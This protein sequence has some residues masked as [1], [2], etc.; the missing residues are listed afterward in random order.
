MSS[1]IHCT[2]DGFADAMKRA[3]K[4]YGDRVFELSE[5]SAK[6]A[7]RQ[8]VSELKRTSPVGVNG[9]YAR[10]WSHKALRAQIMGY[11]EII[12]NRTDYQLTHLL[13]KPHPVNGPGKYPTYTDHT[14]KIKAV[15]N[16]YGIKFYE[17]V[18]EKL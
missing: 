13:E 3:L 18:I 15:E 16:K 2:P 7:S 14:G 17:G 9:T 12:Y 6:T 4:V 5:E 10:G 8:A 1:T 11:S